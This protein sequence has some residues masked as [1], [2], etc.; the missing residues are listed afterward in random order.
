[1]KAC[2]G[3]LSLFGDNV[4]GACAHESGTYESKSKCELK[5][6]LIYTNCREVGHCIWE[7]DE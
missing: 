4:P 3:Q 6:R 2:E 7:G 5:G 1:M